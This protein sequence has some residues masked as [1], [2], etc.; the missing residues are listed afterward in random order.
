VRSI[1]VVILLLLGSLARWNAVPGI[2]PLVVLAVWP[3]SPARQPLRR[4]AYRLLLCA[5]IVLLVWGVAGK[6]LDVTVIHAEKT[7][8]ANMLPLWDLTGM[9]HRL[10]ENL[11]PGSWSPQQ[12][13][14]IVQFCYR[15]TDDNNLIMTG[16]SCS[17]I[18][19]SLVQQGYWHTT[20]LFPLWARMILNHPMTYLYTRATYVHTLF[21]PND[22]F[23]F[24]ADDGANTFNHHPGM[25]F[26]TEKR[27]LWF[28]RTAPIIHFPFTLAF[29]MAAA[30]ILTASFAIAV[31][32]GEAGCYPSLLLSLS[33]GINL[34]PLVIIGPDGQLR[35]AYWPI[36]AISIA[37]LIARWDGA[38]PLEDAA[39]PVFAPRAATP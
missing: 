34:W 23:M 9:S 11:L 20:I 5:P 21:W 7:G 28:C 38:R 6:L 13:E 32:R 29:W 14:Q 18:R 19:E 1:V 31:M 30:L 35:F 16:S 36:A 17:F 8:F 15:A 22:I 37:L 25:L 2:V 39:E 24:D 4:T 12:S 10:G 33:A 3:Q 27:W 26:Q